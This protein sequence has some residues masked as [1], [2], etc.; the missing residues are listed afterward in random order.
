MPKV[1]S[2]F[3]NKME[4]DSSKMNFALYIIIALLR[5]ISVERVAL[6]RRSGFQFWILF[7]IQIISAFSGEVE[8]G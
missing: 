6:T 4:R 7:N 8:L 1:R 5:M 2:R 3:P